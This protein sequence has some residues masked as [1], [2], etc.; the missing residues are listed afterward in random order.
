[1]VAEISTSCFLTNRSITI[2]PTT[3]EASCASYFR[4]PCFFPCTLCQAKQYVIV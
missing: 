2:F 3:G 4:I 1:M